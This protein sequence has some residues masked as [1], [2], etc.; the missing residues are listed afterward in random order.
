MIK[1]LT[2][3][4]KIAGGNGGLGLSTANRGGVGGAGGV[5]VSNT[6][7]VTT[8][9]N[10]GAIAGGNGGFGIGIGGAGGAGV[11]NAGTVTTLSSSGAIAGGNGGGSADA[12]RGRCW[13][14]ELRHY[15]DV[16]HRGTIGGG[17]GSVGGV[18][19]LNAKRSNN[20]IVQQRDRCRISGGNG[21]Q[22]GSPFPPR[23]YRTP[24]RSGA[25]SNNG[26]IR[27]G[28]GASGAGVS[29]AGTIGA[30]SNGGA[31]RGANA[32]LGG[33]GGT[34]VLSVRTVTTL[35]NSWRDW[36]AE[37]AAPAA[38]LSRVASAASACR[39]PGRSRA[40]PTAA[41]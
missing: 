36:P 29:N 12:A 19:V 22:F 7:T 23:A 26:A 32:G 17:N 8:L 9:S 4:N 16:D 18:G 37:M 30:L 21:E 15:P 24:G 31:I 27:G 14:C 1:W 13:S 38:P 11:S 5:G 25:L 10:S 28:N 35:S 40:S 6:G 2:N 39:T 33:N 3:S 34:G 20:R 41:R